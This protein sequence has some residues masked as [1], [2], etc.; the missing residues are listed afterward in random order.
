MELEFIKTLLVND[1]YI[2]RYLNSFLLDLMYKLRDIVLYDP[3]TF[4]SD[5]TSELH[6]IGTNEN[7]VFYIFS[8]VSTVSEK[9]TAINNAFLQ[10]KLKL[11]QFILE[12]KNTNQYIYTRFQKL[13]EYGIKTDSVG[14]MCPGYLEKRTILKEIKYKPSA[15]SYNYLKHHLAE[16]LSDINKSFILDNNN[17]VNV[18][19]GSYIFK[20][21]VLTLPMM[22]YYSDLGYEITSGLSGHSLTYLDM[23]LLFNMSPYTMALCLCIKLVP[24]HHSIVEIMMSMMDLNIIDKIIN[25]IHF[26][27]KECQKIKNAKNI[28]NTING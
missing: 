28:E 17:I 15:I 1:T 4:L 27:E 16:D 7:L 22:K 5:D 3:V 11:Y 20:D 13:H 14:F 26:L 18:T 6:N 21:I 19:I 23:A 2:Y 10:N 24:L 9:L 8:T 25:P 12:N